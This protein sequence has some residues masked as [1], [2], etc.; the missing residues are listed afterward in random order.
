MN[1]MATDN[2]ENIETIPGELMHE[3]EFALL[4]KMEEGPKVGE[5][6]WIPKSLCEFDI[7]DNELQVERWFALKNE[8]I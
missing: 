8:F 4:I 2:P 7:T 3:T 1:K 6:I 5:N